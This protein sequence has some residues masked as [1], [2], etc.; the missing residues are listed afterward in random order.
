MNG[1][2]TRQQAIA[3]D[4]C[5]DVDCI[6]NFQEFDVISGDG[7]ASFRLL[8]DALKVIPPGENHIEFDTI[9]AVHWLATDGKTIVSAWMHD[10]GCGPCGI[11]S[12]QGHYMTT[13]YSQT[14]FDALRKSKDDMRHADSDLRFDLR[15]RGVSVSEYLGC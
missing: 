6:V 7:G 12:R 3:E 11:G 15:C 5:I 13:N 1:R 4:L 9:G 10:T 8:M 14:L 2:K